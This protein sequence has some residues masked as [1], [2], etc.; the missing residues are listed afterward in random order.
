MGRLLRYTVTIVRELF[1]IAAAVGIIGGGYLGFQYLGANKEI[2][3]AEPAPR[4]D[5]LVETMAFKPTRDPLP[6]R[7][8]GFIEPF[9]TVAV[10]APTGG[11]IVTLHPAITDR[12]PFEKGDVLVE[13]DASAERAQI[14]QARASIAATEARL[15]LVTTQLE[16][17]QSLRERDTVAQSTVDDLVGQRDE[18]RANLQ[19]Q[20][21][22]LL[23]SEI[24]LENKIV[25]APFDGM[26]QAKEAEIGNVVAGGS[27]IAQIYTDDRMEVSV[28]IRESDAALIPGLF[29]GNAAPAT[30]S[31]LFA[32][33]EKTWRGE[34]VRVNPALDPQTRT[35]AVTVA[36]R[37]RIDTQTDLAAGAPPA[38]INAFAKVVIEGVEPQ[39]TYAIPSTALRNADTVWILRQD[40]LAFHPARR[41]HVDGETSYVQI[42]GLRPADRLVLTTLAAPQPGAV[43]RDLSRDVQ[44][45]LVVR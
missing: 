39:D 45:S 31:I 27:P 13:I 9:R 30:V 33:A 8:D 11:R 35:L 28:A 18:I 38:F 44:T 5:T 25:R 37:D 3:E 6:I 15:D 41:V 32:G 1:W 16:R 4:Q 42:A 17:A 43:L 2:V 22:Q 29:D 34:V 7:G 20:R 14:E 24:A 19:G 23:T 26:V 40:R 21:A 12:G 36:L 10:S